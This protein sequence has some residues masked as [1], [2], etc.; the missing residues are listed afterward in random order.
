MS[1]TFVTPGQYRN[2]RACMVC[3]IVQLYSKFTKEGYPNC[4]EAIH[5]RD[6]PDKVEDWMYAVKVSSN[7]STIWPGKETCKKEATSRY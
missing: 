3:S 7:V 4:K 2:L 6:N 5:L 1:S